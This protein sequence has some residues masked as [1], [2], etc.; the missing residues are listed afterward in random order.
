MSQMN[1]PSNREAY[2][3]A[4]ELISLQKVRRKIDV[5]RGKVLWQLHANNLFRQA[6]GEGVDTWEE[7]LRSP[8]IGLTTSEANRAM[9]LYEYFVLKF[10]LPENELEQVSVKAL[11]HLLPRVKSGAVTKE[12]AIEL[13]GDAKELTFFEFKER[14]Q[15][16]EV[17]EERTYTYMVMRRCNETKNLSKVVE[18]SNEDVLSVWPELNDY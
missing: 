1:T 8:E 12:E 16:V 7:F 18:I 6:F 4:S 10:E 15:D 2:A 14:L 13:L 3:L 11:T 9:Q 5:V 17:G